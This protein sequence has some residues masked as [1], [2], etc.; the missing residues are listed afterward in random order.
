MQDEME[1][2]YTEAPHKRFPV[3]LDSPRDRGLKDF[4]QK[5][6][7][8]PDFG[9]VTRKANP[10]EIGSLDA[11]G[12]LEVSP[13]VTVN[14]KC[15]PLGRILYGGSLTDPALQMNKTVTDFLKGQQGFRLVLASP[16]VCLDLFREKQKEGFGDAVM[17][18][19][20]LTSL[21]CGGQWRLVLKNFGG[22]KQTEKF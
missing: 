22:C 7:L 3:V 9:Y 18:E 8:G 16:R 19:G 6:V 15:Y 10:D 14:G 21:W 12:N 2:G 13:P 17:F 4:P 5:K 11:F 20:G 1:F